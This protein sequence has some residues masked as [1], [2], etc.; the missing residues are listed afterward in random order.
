MKKFAFTLAEVLITL[1][2][3]GVVAAITLPSVIQNYQE[4][5]MIS[6][7]KK[8]YSTLQNAFNLAIAENGNVRG[9]FD[10]R[11]NGAWQEPMHNILKNYFDIVKYCPSSE[12]NCMDGQRLKF[13]LSDKSEYRG[14][15]P[16]LRGITYILK[17]GTFVAIRIGSEGSGICNI[18]LPLSGNASGYAGQC[19]YITV[20]LNGYKGPNRDGY[21]IFEFRLFNNGILPKGRQ[22]DHSIQSFQLHCINNSSYGLGELGSCTAWVLQNNNMDYLH[23]PDKLSWTGAHSCKD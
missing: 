15:S 13:Y 23:C 6:K 1:T 21:D 5:A 9:W 20:D 18:N 7:L 2:V 22:N 11:A 4:H 19:G 10:D 12:R 16:F 8:T 14:T 3:I 17:D